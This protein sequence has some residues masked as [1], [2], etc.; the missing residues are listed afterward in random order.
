[1]SNRIRRAVVY[2]FAVAALCCITTA[3]RTTI[4][5]NEINAANRR[6]ETVRCVSIA[7][8]VAIPVPSPYTG[9][10]SREWVYRYDQVQRHRARELG[11]AVPRW[12]FVNA[13]S[14]G[15]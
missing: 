3:V 11:C 15:N 9:N 6:Q 14:K 1:V 8:I 13:P 12:H 5:Q 7:E 10:P 4:E 2:L